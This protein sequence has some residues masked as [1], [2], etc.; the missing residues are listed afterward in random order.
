MRKIC[1]LLAAII[2]AGCATYPNI[3]RERLESF[4]QHYSQFDLKMAWGVKPVGNESFVDGLVQNIR[5][6]YMEGVEVWVAVVEA[7]GKSGKPSVSYIIPNQLKQDEIAPFSV[8]LPVRVEPG[9]RLLFTYKYRGNDDGGSDGGG[10][11]NWMQSFETVV[12]SK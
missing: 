10:S 4:P 1:T 12:P 7:S 11:G 8:I 2:L 3:D 6:T 5:Y 9:T